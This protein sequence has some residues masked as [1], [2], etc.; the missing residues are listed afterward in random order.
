M[1]L[2][3]K[4][5]FEELVNIYNNSESLKDFTNQLG[6]KAYRT[7]IINQIQEQYPN[8]NFKSIGHKSKDLT[9]QSFNN[10]TVLSLNKEATKKD[11]H[12][13]WYCKCHCGALITVRSS[14]LLNNEIISC[15]SCAAL[16]KRKFLKGQQF[17]KLT[18]LEDLLETK[19]NRSVCKC[20][21]D[22]GKIINCFAK[23]L[24]NNSITS[25]G[26]LRSSKGEIIL[27]QLFI[28]EGI[29]F[30]EQVSFEDLK[31]KHLLKFDFQ[32]TIEGQNIL[33]EYQGQQH[34]YAVDHFGGQT[35]FEQQKL[36]DNKKRKY[37]VEK[38]IPLIEIPYT[39][40]QKINKDYLL[41]RIKEV[42]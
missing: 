16:R 37:C 42:I 10:L 13:M 14:H 34:Y 15:S 30:K 27:K 7:N 3:E 5:S 9:G 35:K 25:C 32:I 22:C 31:N 41:N 36:N 28:E 29:P 6:Y 33:V 12:S 40:F 24:L 38:G 4:Y 20:K 8:F 23:N 18:V 26:C 21:C 11:G 39:D 1:F 17:G 2:W 19:D